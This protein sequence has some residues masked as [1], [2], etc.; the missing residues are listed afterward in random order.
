M[1]RNFENTGSKSINKL[2][3]FGQDTSAFYIKHDT[4]ITRGKEETLKIF[5]KVTGKKEKEVREATP[6]EEDIIVGGALMTAAAIKARNKVLAKNFKTK[7]IRRKSDIETS[8]II[9][10]SD[11]EVSREILNDSISFVSFSDQKPQKAKIRVQ[12][13]KTTMANPERR[14]ARMPRSFLTL[15]QINIIIPESRRGFKYVERPGLFCSIS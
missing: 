7:Q 11:E 10:E 4:F 12:K 5:M 8:S 14:I 1:A 6:E 13:Q 3:S 15:D 9:Q 2:R